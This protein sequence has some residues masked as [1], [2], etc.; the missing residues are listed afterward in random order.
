MC[1]IAGVFRAGDPA[2]DEAVVRAMLEPLRK[3][4]PDGEGLIREGGLTLGHRRLAIIDLSRNADQPMESASGRLVVSFNGE[5]YNYRE[6]MDEL[7]IPKGSLRTSSDTEILLHAWE[8]W[9]VSCLE[10]L[11]GQWAIALFDR[12][13]ERLWLARDRWGEKPLF[14]HSNSGTLA[15]SS[16]IE[17]L[18]RAPWV[19]REIC[20]EALAEYLTLRYVVSPRTVIRGVRKIPPGHYLVADRRGEEIHEWWAPRYRTREA[21]DA[22]RSLGEAQEEFGSRLA[23]ASRRCLVGDVPVA[24]LLSDGLD[25]NGILAALLQVGIPCP[26]ITYRTARPGTETGVKPA[27]PGEAIRRAEVILASPEEI[28]ED[29]DASLRTLTEPVGDGIVTASYHMIRRARPE[30]TVFLA[31]HGGDELLGGYRLSQDRFRLAAMH[32]ICRMPMP[33]LDRMVKAYTNGAESIRERREALVGMSASRAPEAA[34]YLTQRPLQAR[35]LRALFAPEP[36][37][38]RYLGVIE[39][40]YRECDDEA[41]DLD[42]MQE[43]ALRTFLSEHMLTI[44]DSTAMA[45][46]AEGRLPYLDRDLVELVFGLPPTLRVSRWPGLTNTKVVLRRWS[47]GIVPQD[48]RTRGKSGFR[49]ANIRSLLGTRG[50]TIRSKIMDASFLRRHLGGLEAWIAQPPEVYRRG[51]EGTYWALLALALWGEQAGVN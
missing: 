27:L 2:D 28:I 30:A 47:R 35:D 10:R 38:G 42:R 33:S 23:R 14:L 25:S 8:R 21:R 19:P 40:M 48:V 39:K 49:H 44:A 50:P 31:G 1:G 34:R 20:P 37:P 46:S 36:P 9:G 16:T 45:A 15:F 22:R 12:R 6:L 11:V 3:R 26:T 32:R 29:L 18:L 13:E 43:V 51:R 17:S 24:L 7:E 4:G 41:A 5:I